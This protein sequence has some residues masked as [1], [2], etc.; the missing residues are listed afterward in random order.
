MTNI[1]S[2]LGSNI[3]ENMRNDEIL[4]QAESQQEPHRFIGTL[5]TIP[6][7]GILSPSPS[8]SIK[9]LDS[10]KKPNTFIKQ[11]KGADIIILDLTQFNFDMKEAEL[12]IKSLKY[13]EVPSDKD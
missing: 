12:L 10:V 3:Y 8:E 9:I 2:L 13:N 6:F 7:N 11:V 5:N 4:K 1:N